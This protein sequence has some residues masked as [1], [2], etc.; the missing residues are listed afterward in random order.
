MLSI[1]DNIKSFTM[2]SL[3]TLETRL[4][5]PILAIFDDF[6]HFS[7]CWISHKAFFL[8]KAMYT[9]DPAIYFLMKT[10]KDN[11]VLNIA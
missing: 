4:K 11:E 7:S 9:M 6:G 2:A 5:V 10:N 1:Y 8:E 3:I